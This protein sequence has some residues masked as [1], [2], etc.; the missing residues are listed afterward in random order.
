ME[1]KVL[2]TASTYSHIRSFHLPYLERFRAAGWQV[3]VACGGKK[4][5]IPGA[6]KVFH[7]PLK[8]SMIA[9]GNFWAA[10]QLRGLIRREGYDL[11]TA[12]TSLASFFTRLA[13]LGP[14]RRPKVV[15]VVHGF[16]FDEN[17]PAWK[18]RIL[19]TAER[20]VAPVTDLMLTMD[21]SDYDM[22]RRHGLGKRVTFIPGMGVDFAQLDTAADM[23][24]DLR[25]EL[26]IAADATVL[27]FAGE[28]SKNKSQNVLIRAM[29]L[30]PERVVLVL[31]GEGTR[32]ERCRSL[33][34]EL[35]VN[36]R[37]HFPGYVRDVGR[38]YAAADVVVPSSRSEGL[39]FNVMEAMYCGLPVVASAVKGHVDLV[40]HEE[41]GLLYPYGDHVACARAVERLI[42]DPEL[43]CR[44]GEQA[45][46]SV[47]DYNL[48]RV[49]DIVFA[50]YQSCVK[51]PA[52]NF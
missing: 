4:M 43:A 33:A 1:R 17:S 48:D 45:A 6:D 44:L 50:Q 25:R 13:V 20:M 40:R 24:E 30:L 23:G 39:P 9:P 51:E 35:G 46:G 7:L 14:G 19:L 22:A 28:F 26:G 31:A 34:R 3:H 10:A 15:G 49:G 29:Q 8:K 16:L 42:N 37:V 47:A 11:V 52:V 41:N 18:R 32:L 27:F 38:W 2:F 36:D 12:H 5:D 21:R